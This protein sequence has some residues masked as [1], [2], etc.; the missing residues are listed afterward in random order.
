MTAIVIDM[1]VLFVQR[2][3]Q[4]M[5]SATDMPGFLS[6]LEVAQTADRLTPLRD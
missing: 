1:E 2:Y 5:L 3:P 6:W 4:R